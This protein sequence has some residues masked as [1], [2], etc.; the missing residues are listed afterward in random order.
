MTPKPY[1][2]ADQA[3]GI[4]LLVAV[5]FA[6]W[7]FGTTQEW[8]IWTLN[9]LGYLMGALLAFKWLVRWKSDFGPT[10]W[11]D[12][13]D[14]KWPVQALAALTVLILAYVLVSVLNA[15][16]QIDYTYLPGFASAT[17]IDI[18]YLEPVGWLPASYDGPATLWA[19]FKYLA[20][21]CA[22]WSARDWLL[23]MSRRERRMS[24]VEH[25]QSAI[26]S[27]RLSLLLWTLILSAAG[28]SLVGILQRLDGT[29]KLLWILKHQNP[30][31]VTF[32]PFA[33]RGTAS[34]YLNLMWPIGIA[35]WLSMRR[36]FHWVQGVAARSGSS[37]HVVVLPLVAV[38]LIGPFMTSSRGGILI[39]AALI[40]A[41]GLV[42]WIS[43]RLKRGVKIGLT[44]LAVFLVAVGWSLGGAQMAKRFETLGKD[45]MS[46]REY[47]YANGKKMVSDFNTFGSGA[48]TFPKIYILY[49]TKS[50]EVWEAYAHDDYLETR[51]T[52]G[53]VGMALILAALIMVPICSQLSA[54][55]PIGLTFH[56]LWIAALGGLML[57]AKFDPP[58]QIYSIHFTFVIL[59]AA[60][61]CIR[62]VKG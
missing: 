15:R 16:A 8:S 51:I 13:I 17:G 40:V 35:F 3:T 30:T 6:P 47:V 61:S 46:G 59:C 18:Q 25:L 31:E 39:E 58:F 27:D 56:L 26:P 41:C 19:F 37:P 9:V 42:L 52:F 57:H 45:K 12:G 34:D 62:P 48:E 4:L 24:K 60:W 14:R 29:Q 43:G 23:G 22:F 44:A 20:L 38:I 21:A 2:W 36:R 50:S 49:R 10:R 53:W 55:I 32:G 33:Y 54:G 1:R 7:A 11:D 28:L 5:V